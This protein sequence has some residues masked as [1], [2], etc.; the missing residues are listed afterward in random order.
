ML[1]SSLVGRSPPVGVLL[2]G[3]GISRATVQHAP[4]VCALL[5][6]QSKNRQSFSCA[7]PA[8]AVELRVEANHAD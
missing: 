7:V 4:Q 2:G 6:C 3:S 1:T 5:L 8:I